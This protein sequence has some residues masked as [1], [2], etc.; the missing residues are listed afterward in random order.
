VVTHFYNWQ[1]QWL[2]L[3]LA[4]IRVAPIGDDVA[5]MAVPVKKAEQPDT[6]Q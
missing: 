3:V 2:P 6:S 5:K 1:R 4:K